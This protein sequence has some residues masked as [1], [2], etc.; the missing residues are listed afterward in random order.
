M[1]RLAFS[2]DGHPWRSPAH[3]PHR[4]VEADVDFACQ[5]S[6]QPVLAAL[7]LPIALAPG[8]LDVHLLPVANPERVR[9]CGWGARSQ[10]QLR[11]VGD[12]RSP[13]PL[14]ARLVM[15]WASL[16]DGPA[17]LGDQLRGC[18]AFE[19]AACA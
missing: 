17:Q 2:L 10:E 4:L 9:G 13:Q 18:V 5:G 7:D 11:R 6:R 8:E 1:K 12:A 19:A 3:D 15:T 16:P 14:G